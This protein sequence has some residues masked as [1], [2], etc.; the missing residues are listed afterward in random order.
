MVVPSLPVRNVL[1]PK[2]NPAILSVVSAI[3]SSSWSVTTRMN[4]SPKLFLL[5]VNVL[6][7]P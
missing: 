6:I 2:S 1:S 5:T 4:N 7:F 3:T